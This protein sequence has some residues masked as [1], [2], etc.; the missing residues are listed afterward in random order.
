MNLALNARDAMPD[1]GLLSIAAHNY[2][3]DRGAEG[4]ELSVRDT[5]VGMDDEVKGRLFEPFFTTKQPGVGTGLGLAT[6]YG[7]VQGAAGSLE[8]ESAPGQGATFRVLLPRLPADRPRLAAVPLPEAQALAGRKVLVVDDDPELLALMVRVVRGAGHTVLQAASSHEALELAEKSADLDAL[9]TDVVLAD[10]GGVELARELR[11]RIPRLGVVL[12][13][14]FSPDPQGVGRLLEA[15]A[16]F[17]PK[18][19]KPDQLLRAMSDALTAASQP[20]PGSAGR[21]SLSLVE[22]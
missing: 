2:R 13:S 3:N 15:G 20:E 12:T 19:F 22:H 4:V 1:G 9:I 17:V 6:V 8:V 16:R 18:P 21:P 11:T 7:I 10:M 5:G 14:G